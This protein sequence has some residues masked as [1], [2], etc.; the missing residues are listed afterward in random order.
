MIN[1]EGKQMANHRRKPS[2]QRHPKIIGVDD[3]LNTLLHSVKNTKIDIVTAFASKTE[4]LID[5]LL[6][7]GNQVTLVVGTINHFTDPVFIQFCCDRASNIK[8]KFNFWVDFRGGNSIHWKVYLIA[9]NTVVVGSSNLTTIGLSM[10]RDTAVVF[11]DR[12]LYDGYQYL[13]A[14]I[15]SQNKVVN[16]DALGF[17]QFLEDY[18]EQH[19]KFITGWQGR[20]PEK[21]KLPRP[22]SFRKW[23]TQD[24]AQVLPLFVWERNFTHAERK[25][26][27]QKVRP[28]VLSFLGKDKHGSNNMELILIG[29]C[30]G[31]QREPPYNNGDLILT[32]KA[33][34]A[35]PKFEEADIVI[36]GEGSWWLC[37]PHGK[38]VAAPFDLSNDVKKALKENAKGWLQED[39]TYLDSNELRTLLANSL[40]RR[41]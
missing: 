13:I 30:N 4:N 36:Y 3:D 33:N 21:H 25:L 8:S 12:R 20:P 32:V 9:P 15:T 16:Q 34:G 6:K 11:K 38:R 7:A 5:S 24:T 35:Y 41:D 22:P 23:L 37:R 29:N 39:K 2:N 10:K 18:K 40:K 27:T 19:R 14:Q 28:K 31:S 17:T 26:F 1:I